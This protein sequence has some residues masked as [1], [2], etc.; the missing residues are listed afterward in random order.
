[1]TNEKT[2]KADPPKRVRPHALHCPEP[3]LTQ[4]HFR[5][6]VNVNNIVARHKNTGVDPFAHRASSLRF[7]FATSQ[8]FETAMFEVANVQN[9][10]A[11]LPA[12]KR[13][14]FDNDP[15]VWLARAA[16]SA[17]QPD[18]QLTT[19]EGVENA[20]QEAVEPL[21]TTSEVD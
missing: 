8:D 4:Q 14:E 13:A 2:K 7:G 21:N 16:E 10:F 1:M 18:N 3:T 19:P 12:A 20:S 5:D 6:E 15:A 11:M 17:E 9:A